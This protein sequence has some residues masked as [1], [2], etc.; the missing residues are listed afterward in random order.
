MNVNR[1]SAWPGLGRCLAGPVLVVIVA[2][3]SFLPARGEENFQQ[4]ADA[5][6]V[7]K[8]KESDIVGVTAAVSKNG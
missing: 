2:L 6:V 3:S 7:Q 5:L 1:P 4:K 8:V